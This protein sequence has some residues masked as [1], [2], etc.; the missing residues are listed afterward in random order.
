MNFD[1]YPASTGQSA[2]LHDF[3]LVFVFNPELD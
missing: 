3:E 2:A 1:L